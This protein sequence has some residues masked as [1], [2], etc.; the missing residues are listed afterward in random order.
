MPDYG[1]DI[2]T[3]PG[4]DPTFTLIGGPRIVAEACARR[5][6]TPHGALVDAPNYGLDLRAFVNA[7]IDA[8]TLGR[9]PDLIAA[10]CEKDERVRGATAQASYGAASMTLTVSVTLE[11]AAGPFTLVL[12]VTAATLTL[13]TGPTNTGS[14]S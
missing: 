7:S 12:L 11:L 2:S 10:E 14:G 5:L 13:I 3:F 8:G 4:L 6:M 9:L 1:Q